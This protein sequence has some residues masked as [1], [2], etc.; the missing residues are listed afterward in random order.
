MLHLEIEDNGAG[1]TPEAAKR[2]LE[3]F[4]VTRTVGLGLGLTVAQKIIENHHGQLTISSLQ[5]GDHGKVR[6]SLPLAT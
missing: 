6:I 4:F 1:F 5:N 2:A 3:P